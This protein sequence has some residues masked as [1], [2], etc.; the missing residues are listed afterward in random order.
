MSCS[1]LKSCSKKKRTGAIADEC[2]VVDE[3]E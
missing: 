2:E 3:N 1:K